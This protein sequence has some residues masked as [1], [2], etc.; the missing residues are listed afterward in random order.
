VLVC[1]LERSYKYF[2]NEIMA[3]VMGL[4]SAVNLQLETAQDVAEILYLYQNDGFGFCGLIIRQA[5][6]KNEWC[7][8]KN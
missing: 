7:E 8:L 4:V 2:Q 6:L 1:V 5:A 3:T